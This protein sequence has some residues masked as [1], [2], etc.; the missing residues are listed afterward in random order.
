MS[1]A[2][3]KDGPISPC[4]IASGLYTGTSSFCLHTTFSIQIVQLC[5]GQIN[6]LCS[7]ELLSMLHY[8]FSQQDLSCLTYTLWNSFWTPRYLILSTSSIFLYFSM[9]IPFVVKHHTQ[10]FIFVDS[11][12]FFTLSN[13]WSRHCNLFSNA[14]ILQNR[15]SSHCCILKE[16]WTGLCVIWLDASCSDEIRVLMP[17]IFTKFNSNPWRLVLLQLLAQC[18][19]RHW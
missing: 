6:H 1:L 17:N 3:T 19:E 12:K 13:S 9:V 18:L 7:V 5:F 10:T 4:S 15:G 14:P 16:L 2:C 8:P 11:N